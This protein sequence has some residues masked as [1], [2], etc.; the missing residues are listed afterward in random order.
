MKAGEAHD[1][2]H[3]EGHSRHVATV[4]EQRQ[5]HVQDDEP[6]H[7]HEHG[8]DTGDDTIDGERD[9]PVGRRE[10]LEEARDPARD[11][12]ADDR[13]DP[14]EEVGRDL[15]HQLEDD[16]HHREEDGQAQQTAGQNAVKPV[17]DAVA[18]DGRAIDDLAYDPVDIA[19]A[20]VGD[21]DVGSISVHRLDALATRRCG[22]VDS[23]TGDLGDARKEVGLPFEQLDGQPA[24]LVGGHKVGLG[25]DAIDQR[26]DLTLHLGAVVDVEGRMIGAADEGGHASVELGDEA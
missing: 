15:D 3:H 2:V 22:S 25:G 6:R 13:V 14:V 23:A 20:A 1:A 17:G 4:L 10:H 16:E 26:A 5:E 11:G 24:R 18:R 9:E 21:G 12:T 7:E 8:A 19:V